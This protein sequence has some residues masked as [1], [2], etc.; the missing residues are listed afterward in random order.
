MLVSIKIQLTHIIMV[1]KSY[2]SVLVHAVYVHM[3]EQLWTHVIMI[4]TIIM[5]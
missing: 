2:L 4:N 3:Y 5:D 1:C